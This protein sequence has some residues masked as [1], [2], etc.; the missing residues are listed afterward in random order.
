MVLKLIFFLFLIIYLNLFRSE[1]VNKEVSKENAI[2]DTLVDN[3]DTL[4]FEKEII[5]DKQQ[6]NALKNNLI[7]NNDVAKDK[8][9]FNSNGYFT[10]KKPE[11]YF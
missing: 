2:E 5:T 8:P 11:E 3:K 7:L 6:I 9:I 4:I 10:S 1:E